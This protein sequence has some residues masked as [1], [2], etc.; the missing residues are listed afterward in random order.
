MT[1]CAEIQHYSEM[2]ALVRIGEESTGSRCT[3][4]SVMTKST[5]EQLLQQIDFY[6]ALLNSLPIPFFAK[7]R[8][9]R[10]VDCNRAFEATFGVDRD[11]LVGKTV[12]DLW[13]ADLARKYRE[14]DRP[15]LEHVEDQEYEAVAEPRDG[16]RRQIHFHKASI[17]DASGQSIGLVGVALDVTPERATEKEMEAYR[18][19]LEEMVRQKSARLD[20]ALADKAA[21]IANI[22]RAIRTP[23]HAVVNFSNLGVTRCAPRCANDD[24]GPYCAKAGQRAERLLHLVDQFL[25]QAEREAGERVYVM[26]DED[27]L[28]L[29]ECTVRDMMAST[30]NRGVT[31][32]IDAQTDNTCVTVDREAIIQVMVNLLSNAVNVSPKSGRVLLVISRP[33]QQACIELRV[34]DDGPGVQEGE[35]ELIFEPFQRGSA[36]VSGSTRKGLGLAIAR[37]IARDHGGELVAVAA[38]PS[39]GGEFRLTLPAVNTPED[40]YQVLI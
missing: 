38:G 32:R 25:E 15:L 14:M 6:K 19:N 24:P 17:A 22:S 23:L 9:G 2:T 21:T 34:T 3:R 30:M 28:E 11:D 12:D 8:D 31:V 37:D 16:Q 27:L 20:A 1:E 13:P 7:D 40:A 36:A 39:G 18:E 26:A 35:T 10:Y 29:A 4:A 33:D 5:E